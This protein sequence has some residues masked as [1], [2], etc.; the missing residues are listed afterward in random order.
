MFYFLHKEQL[1]GFPPI[2]SR[3]KFFCRF[4]KK[5]VD[6]SE[7][8][9]Y[10]SQ[11]VARK[12]VS[13]EFKKRFEKNLKKLLTN[14]KQCDIIIKSL[15]ERNFVE[16]RQRILKIKQRNYKKDIMPVITLRRLYFLKTLRSDKTLKNEMQKRKL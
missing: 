6:K 13:T 10:Y 9:C 12:N 3:W 4:L 8:V 7:R 5:G 14:K 15:N 1:K 11:A 2:V 16:N